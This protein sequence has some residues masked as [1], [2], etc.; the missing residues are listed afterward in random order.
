MESIAS[1]VWMIL[2]SACGAIL[3]GFVAGLFSQRGEDPLAHPIGWIFCGIGAMVALLAWKG[4]TFF[5]RMP[6]SLVF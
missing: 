5:F 4:A 6:M 2:A 3:G 1:Y